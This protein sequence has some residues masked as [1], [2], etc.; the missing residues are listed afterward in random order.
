MR[1]IPGVLALCLVSFLALP[2]LAQEGEDP[3]D[4]Q[5]R[6]RELR[7]AYAR[8]RTPEEK[9]A[10]VE[11]IKKLRLLEVS[12]DPSLGSRP[13]AEDFARWTAP[14]GLSTALGMGTWLAK[15]KKLTVRDIDKI[16]R[17]VSEGGVSDKE[18][19]DLA[20]LRSVY[21]DLLS[22]N[23][24]KKLDEILGPEAPPPADPELKVDLATDSNNDGQVDA[25]DDAVEESQAKRLIVNDDDDGNRAGPD[26]KDEV[27][28]GAGDRGDMGLMRLSLGR[29]EEGTAVSL[30]VAPAGIVRV[31]SSDGK[32]VVGLGA[33]TGPVAAVAEAS[34]FLVEGCAEGEVTITATVTRG[35]RKASD[36]V[37][38]RVEAEKVY[39][40]L[41]GY[42]GEEET[43]LASDIAK[44]GSVVDALKK[45][46]Y[47]VYDEGTSFNQGTIDAAFT[48]ENRKKHPKI[49]II[50]RSTSRSDFL[51]YLDR[52]TVRGFFWGSHGYME[53]FIG[54]PDSELLT[55]ES[56][57]WSC[58]Q[59]SPASNDERNFVRDVKS[60]VA[61]QSQLPLD[62]AIMHSCA[63]GGLG[64]DYWGEPWHYT[65]PDTKARVQAK[66]GRF[67]PAEELKYTTFNDLKPYV[68]YLITYNGSAYFGLH[69]VNRSLVV[70]SISE[71]GAR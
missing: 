46:G 15:D 37:K 14:L 48:E 43:Y 28:D 11:E 21:R 33:S 38:V 20:E 4:F 6:R 23:A 60:R 13:S 9:R 42:Q 51:R 55:L 68:G 2:V 12:R 50:D 58:P 36:A 16:V 19:A 59:G 65:H 34:E 69:D 57:I 66:F 32:V 40:F 70:R 8:A 41:F 17:M 25:A 63:T 22:K 61:K 3:A 52:G 29:I 45:A 27:I 31:F 54:C 64:T 62:F 5:E 26:H 71:T 35:A 7:E 24:A 39:L 1:T 67:P 44:L 30:A 56:R 53:P 47:T 10:V 49:V 18:K